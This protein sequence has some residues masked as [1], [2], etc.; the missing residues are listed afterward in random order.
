MDRTASLV[1]FLDTIPVVDH[2]CHGITRGELTPAG[3]AELATE[4]DWPPPGDDDVFDTPFGLAV[5]AECAPLLGLPRH[6][7]GDVYLEARRRLGSAEVARRL[8]SA[9]NIATYLVDTGHRS[10]DILEPP[11]LAAVTGVKAAEV[12]R[13]EAMAERLARDGVGA[14]EFAET[15]RTRLGE[16]LG[17][18]VAMKSVMAYRYGLDFDPDRPAEAEIRHA[19]SE[20]LAAASASG[21]WRLDHPVLLRA[22]LWIAVDV[23]KPIQ[24]HVGYG[25]S[26]IEL[27]RCDPTRMTEFLR[28]T[29][30]AGT[31]IMLLHNYPFVREAGY[32]SQIYPHVWFDTGAAVGFTGAS[33]LRIVRE[34]LELAPFGKLLFSTDAFG[35]PE[36]FLCGARLLRRGLARVFA[37]WLD[38]NA[39][40]ESDAHTYLHMITS[41]NA[42]QAYRLDA[43]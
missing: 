26:D 10:D 23:G 3:F 6:A 41:G 20:W 29:V 19:A 30:G 11:E 37:E 33:S 27:H 17:S 5:R 2:H 22:L 13:L 18:A 31:D 7:R 8:L 38:D 34:S 28:R 39:I 15:F 43:A 12:V 24:M 42:V 21:R 4:S 40:S 16:A 36:L 25:D 14:A 1:E 9:S 35:L 32:L